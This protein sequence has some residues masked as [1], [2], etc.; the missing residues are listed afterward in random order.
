M[1]SPETTKGLS[2]PVLPISGKTDTVIVRACATLP[3]GEEK[4]GLDSFPRMR[5][6]P[7]CDVPGCLKTDRSRPWAHCASGPGRHPSGPPVG[8]KKK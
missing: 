6:E 5:Q 1:R 3:L 4:A 7:S 2:E 8:R